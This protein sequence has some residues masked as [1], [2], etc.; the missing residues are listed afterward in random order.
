MNR[1][2]TILSC[3]MICM[4][5]TLHAG[6]LRVGMAQVDITPQ[7]PYA[8]SGYYHA[9]LS[10][11]AIDPLYAKAIVFEQDGQRA[12]MMACDLIGIGLGLS[13]HVK[14]LIEKQTGIPAQNIA[15]TATHSHTGPSYHKSVYLYLEALESGTALPDDP[16]PAHLIQGMV[17]AFETAKMNLQDARLRTGVGHQLDPVV[18]FNRR[19]V[20]RDGETKT[21]AN[22][23]DPNVIRSAGPIDP[24]VPVIAFDH[25]QTGKPFGALSVFALHLDTVG[26]IKFSADYPYFIA[27][28]LQE[29]HGPEFVSVFGAGTCGDINHSDPRRKE[30]NKTP[31]IGGALAQTVRQTWQ[32][33]K[34]STEAPNLAVRTASVDLP[35]QDVTEEDLTWAR[36]IVAD[37]R[38]GK[39]IPFLN[40]VKAYKMLAVEGFRTGKKGHRRLF[41]NQNTDPNAEAKTKNATIESLSIPI[42][43]FR[44]D[45]ET[46]IVTLPGEVFVELGMAVKQRSPFPRTLVIELADADDIIYVPTR[47]AYRGGGYEVINSITQPGSG[48]KLVD[49]AITL[50]NELKP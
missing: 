21:W 10:E 16:Y 43:A 5:G 2:L 49:A 37:D 7:Q 45:T 24:E 36:Q 39:K 48:E 44:L 29:D 17:G 35:L 26:G 20:M 4:A 13:N 42:H 41:V 9:R 22:F 25:A 46:A 15:I 47:E 34:P 31:F 8:M 19:F 40:E 12:A 23:R 27:Q 14:Q 28:A 30:R 50:L 18:A 1:F 32:T 6:P 3:L 11:G 38:A 33:L